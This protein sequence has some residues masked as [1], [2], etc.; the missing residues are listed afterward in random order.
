MN[1]PFIFIDDVGAA[2]SSYFVMAW[3]ARP[4]FRR[5]AQGRKDGFVIARNIRYG[6]CQK[7]QVRHFSQTS[8]KWMSETSLIFVGYFVASFSSARCALI[9]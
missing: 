8:L 5:L 2:E 7:L 6:T 1:L 4:S 9:F 3:F